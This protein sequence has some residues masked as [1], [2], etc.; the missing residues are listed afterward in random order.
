MTTSSV[1]PD[2]DRASRV[3]SFGIRKERT[4][5]LDPRVRKDD[6]KKHKDDREKRKDEQK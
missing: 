2:P 4:M 5:T 1:M 3:V 6:E